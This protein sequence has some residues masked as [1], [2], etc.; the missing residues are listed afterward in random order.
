MSGEAPER[1]A[2]SGI[3][4]GGVSIEGDVYTGGGDFVAGDKHVHIVQD[5]AAQRERRSQRILLEK[6]RR[7]WIS[8]VLDSSLQALG[9]F[10]TRQETRAD[11]VA[12]P[13]QGVLEAPPGSLL[14]DDP[15]AAA[16][17]GLAGAGLLAC[18][19]A[20]GQAL[21]I[22]GEP[23]SGKTTAL[24]ALAQALA[25]RAGVDDGQPVPVVLNLAT[26]GTQRSDLDD[27]V[28]DELNSKYQI[29]REIGRRWLAHN[30]LALLLDG[31]DEVNPAYHRAC[32]AEI[33]QFRQEHGLTGM[34]VCC[35][36]EEY[37][38]AGLPLQ[39]GSAVVL[40][41]LAPEQV[42]EITGRAGERLAAVR[43]LLEQDPQ[44]QELAQTPLMLSILAVAYQDAGAGPV[45]TSAEDP[46]Q[47]RE[48]LLEAYVHQVFRRRGGAASPE[49]VLPAISFLA[50]RM[51]E[52]NQAIFLIE[53]LQPGWLRRPASRLA[54]ALLTR[55]VFGLLSGLLFVALNFSLLRGY[56]LDGPGFL[57]IGL[58][59]GLAGGLVAGL[60]YAWQL[61]RAAGH[62]A[63]A[64]SRT[65]KTGLTGLLRRYV[66]PFFNGESLAA[67][68]TAAA[69]SLA[70][71]PGISASLPFGQLGQTVLVVFVP[72]LFLLAYTLIYGFTFSN[73]GKPAAAEIDPVEAVRWSWGSAARG[74]L[75]GGVVSGFVSLG[76]VLLA[77]LAALILGMIGDFSLVQVIVGT[78]VATILV[79]PLVGIPVAGVFFLLWGV[80]GRQVEASAGPNHGIR[81]SLRNAAFSFIVTG[82]AGG[83]LVAVHRLVIS[84]V[85][86]PITGANPLENPLSYLVLLLAFGLLLG[87]ASGLRNGGG[88]VLQHLALRLLLWREKSLPWQV[89]RLLDRCVDLA[90]LR[91]VGNGYL[92]IH[93]VF[94]EHF[95]GQDQA[96]A[97]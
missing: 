61:G 47:S 91:R 73:Y 24:L 5:P 18:Y 31:L 89:S 62:P 34:A 45:F 20:C 48:R 2:G 52:H 44:V 40:K 28:V 21:L 51:G 96:S 9:W 72:A 55:L 13:W 17:T 36:L 10:E 7:F 67:G 12:Q 33:N 54:Y 80:L 16:G 97:G 85:I 64:P 41:R 37:Q 6:V 39:V 58:L 53:G 22:L 82:L 15:G 26:W 75:V 83:A 63:R 38:R 79:L 78:A 35:R 77:N 86:D 11:L 90:L 14:P 59:P 49:Q 27:W 66:Y 1:E 23:G 84:L 87:A 94:Q 88:A 19:E 70:I 3:H 57:R 50:R 68:L 8:G 43:A 95:A 81:Q 42:R 76:L 74:L 93:R 29:P 25:G 92:F 71:Y 30:D 69:V 56:R 4:A 46:K 65:A 32:L 60:L